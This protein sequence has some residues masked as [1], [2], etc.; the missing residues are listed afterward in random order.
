GNARAVGGGVGGGRWTS[1]GS[2]LT[3]S[4]LA[5]LLGSASPR[6]TVRWPAYLRVASKTPNV[7]FLKRSA[8]FRSLC[9]G[10]FRGGAQPRCPHFSQRVRL[11]S[12]VAPCQFADAVR[13]HRRKPTS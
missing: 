5:M 8:H 4:G 11:L 2:L 3:T 13:D 9:M 10:S 12:T 7:P 6:G 1:I